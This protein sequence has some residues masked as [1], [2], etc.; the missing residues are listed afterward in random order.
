MY[1]M[2]IDAGTGSARAVIF[3]TLAN[4]VSIGQQEWTHLSE[5]GVANSMGFD[6]EKNWQ[7]I[8]TCIKEAIFKAGIKSNQIAAITATSM[9]EGIV[10]YDKDGNELF[11]VAN[12]DARAVKEVAELNEKYPE[13]EKEFYKISGQTFALGAL[14]RLLWVKNNKPH[15]YEKVASMNMISDWVLTKLSGVI[16][17]EPSNAGTSGVFSLKTRQF[18][19]S[20]ADKLGL[21]DDIFPKVYE[22]GTVIAEISKKASEETGLHVSTKVVMGGGDVQLGSAGLGVVKAG[23]CAILGGTF[24]Q[25]IVNIEGSIVDPNM[26]IRINPH[27]IPGLSQA[28]GI[29]FF[30]G[31]VMRW[32][33]DT[34]C[35]LEKLEAQKLG[36]D[37][38]EYLE[39]LASKVPLGSYGIMP[40]FSDVM[41]YS[42]WYHAAPSFINLSLETTSKAAMFRSLEEN[43][44]IVSMLNL[45]SILDFTKTDI[46]TITFAGGASKGALWSQILSDVTGKNIQIPQVNEATAL[47][48]AFAA[49]VGV[50]EYSSIAEVAQTLVKW[51]KTYEPDLENFR[52]YQEISQQWKDIY[53]AQ[54]QL[55]DRGLT[56]SMWKA[57]G[58]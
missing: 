44:A 53:D 27:V 13:L 2:T 34:F 8:V 37:T 3:D 58:L 24:W 7:I 45:N 26:N 55:V 52:K 22:S 56:T 49:G 36:I 46:D 48:G 23:Q 54:L 5:D 30:S 1:F 32:F 16:A 18:E 15:I 51:D 20:M 21:K 41:K 31:M 10:L 17:A 50:G 42:S 57:P 28:E 43:A 39:S 40:I 35:D 33:R 29:T 25:Q 38:Y 6:Y 4:Q 11:G 47:G 14:P 12:V 9:R 19:P